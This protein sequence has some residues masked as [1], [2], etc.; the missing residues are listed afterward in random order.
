MTC[1][2]G[3][4]GEREEEEAEEE[5]WFDPLQGECPGKPPRLVDDQEEWKPRDWTGTPREK[6][7]RDRLNNDE[8]DDGS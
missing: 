8:D 7:E 3:G 4:F 1:Y 2:D 5:S 6:M